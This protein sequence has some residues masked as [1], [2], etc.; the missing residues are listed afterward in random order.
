MKIIHVIIENFYKL[1]SGQ[2]RRDEKH[3]VCENF[4]INWKALLSPSRHHQQHHKIINFLQS[5][6]LHADD[7]NDDF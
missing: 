5:F 2:K 1:K 7:D 6:T 4:E 3:F